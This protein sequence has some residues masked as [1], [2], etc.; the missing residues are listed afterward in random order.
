ML[1]PHGP[2]GRFI[3]ADEVAAQKAANLKSP[4]EGDTTENDV[5]DLI[6][7][8]VEEPSRTMNPVNAYRRP[9][10]GHL[11]QQHSH[12]HPSQLHRRQHRQLPQSPAPAPPVTLTTPPSFPSHHRHGI[13]MHHIPHP[14]AHARP[15]HPALNFEQQLYP[16]QGN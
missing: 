16:D 5:E 6:E 2:G 1:R 8:E 11:Y 10:S 15:H 14:Q 12:V 13:Q 4:G 7:E 9:G 3:T